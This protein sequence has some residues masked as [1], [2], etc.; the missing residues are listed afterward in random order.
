MDLYKNEPEF[1][2]D[3]EEDE[4]DSEND[5]EEENFYCEICDREFESL[6]TLDRHIQE[7]QTC[8]IDGCTFTAHPKIVEKH[9]SMQHATGLYQRMKNA[10]SDGDLEKWKAERKK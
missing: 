9:I 10:M 4:N 3:E 8:K 7:H 1:K 2:Y 5:S 6:E